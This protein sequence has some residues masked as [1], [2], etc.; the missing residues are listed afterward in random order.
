MIDLSFK[1]RS[2]EFPRT[3]LAAWNGW[4]PGGQ[5]WRAWIFLRRPNTGNA[6]TVALIVAERCWKSLMNLNDMV[7][8]CCL[9]LVANSARK[10]VKDIG[11]QWLKKY[12]LGALGPFHVFLVLAYSP[13]PKGPRNFFGMKR[14]VRANFCWLYNSDHQYRWISDDPVCW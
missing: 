11:Q 7:I 4:T 6:W 8:R 9:M 14:R 13:V 1:T 12:V 10:D 3:S 2:Q 5:Q